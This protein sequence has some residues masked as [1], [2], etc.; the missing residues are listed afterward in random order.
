MGLVWLCPQSSGPQR[1]KSYSDG[2]AQT[3][4]SY[5]AVTHHRYLP[6]HTSDKKVGTNLSASDGGRSP[7]RSLKARQITLIKPPAVVCL[8]IFLSTQRDLRLGPEYSFQGSSSE[9]TQR[10]NQ[11]SLLLSTETDITLNN[12]I[13][14]GWVVIIPHGKYR[15]EIEE[16]WD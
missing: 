14:A 8:F 5:Y 11:S 3:R 13:S 1:I 12:N 6:N 15:Q 9:R 4:G 16:L 2:S 7:T 10:W